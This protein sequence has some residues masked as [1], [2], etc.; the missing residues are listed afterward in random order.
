MYENSDVEC[1]GLRITFDRE[2]LWR[3][4]QVDLQAGIY[5]EPLLPS[6]YRIMEIK[7]ADA[8]PMWLV[9]LLDEMQ[10]YPASY[11]KYGTAYERMQLQ[12][13]SA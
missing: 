11:S 3:T 12:K 1:Q 4:E 10:I 13:R 6:G 5:G 9:K 8:M 7:A 2:L